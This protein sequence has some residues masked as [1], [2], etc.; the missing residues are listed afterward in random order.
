MDPWDLVGTSRLTPT[1]AAAWGRLR[2]RRSWMPG[3][4]PSAEGIVATD[5]ATGVA[6]RADVVV[7]ERSYPGSNQNPHEEV[8]R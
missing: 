3:S 4:A 5:V 1:C 7:D 8:E 6:A 2:S